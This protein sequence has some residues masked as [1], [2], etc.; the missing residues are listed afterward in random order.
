MD[1]RQSPRFPVHLRAECRRS[2]DARR[3]AGRVLDISESGLL[4]QLSERIEVGQNLSL[5]IFIGSDISKSIEAGV[6]V[7][8]RQF[9]KGS[10]YRIGAKFIHV[11]SEERIKLEILLKPVVSQRY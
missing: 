10:G 8:W 9:N 5:K 4:L 11:P 1:R 7:V 6:Q 3:H 2:N